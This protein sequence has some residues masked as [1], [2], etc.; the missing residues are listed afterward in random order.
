MVSPET[1][2]ATEV[3]IADAPVRQSANWDFT[4]QQQPL[5]A[6][7]V[8]TRFFANVRQDTGEAFGIVTD[9]YS[10][11]QN[12]DLLG[13]IEDIIKARGLGEVKRKVMVTGGGARLHANYLFNNIG[14]KI[15]NQDIVFNLK[16]QNSHD[17]SLRVALAVG[18]FRLICSNGAVAPLDA[19]NLTK[20]HTDALSLEFAGGAIDNAIENFHRTAPMLEAM[21]RTRLSGDEGHRVLNGLVVRKE[22]SERQSDEVREIWNAP[23]HR[24][25]SERNL[26]NLWNATTQHLTHTVAGKKFELAE[27][28]NRTVTQTLGRSAMAGNISELM[29]KE[30]A[31]RKPRTHRIT[32][33]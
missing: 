24:E 23:T 11:M 8:E 29:V 14:F 22:L 4:V 17:G 1:L 2:N 32:L 15:G 6:N 28:I 13:N 33:N 30:L 19:I 12:R 7:G 5:F 10:V 3:E 31:P 27:R 21:Y 20:K 26:Y 9:R 18:L 16:V 25:D